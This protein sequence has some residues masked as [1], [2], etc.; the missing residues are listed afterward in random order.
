[1]NLPHSAYPE[2]VEGLSFSTK[3]RQPFDRLRE[4][5][6]VLHIQVNGSDV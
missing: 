4:T 6:K 1:M 3:E 5:E 2:P